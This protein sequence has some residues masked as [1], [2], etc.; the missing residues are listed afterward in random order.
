M[1]AFWHATVRKGKSVNF[2]VESINFIVYRE[3]WSFI[4]KGD[5]EVEKISMVSMIGAFKL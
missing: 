4:N 5:I 2:K 3:D 1:E